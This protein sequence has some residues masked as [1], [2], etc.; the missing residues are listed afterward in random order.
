MKAGIRFP[1]C[2]GVLLA[3]GGRS[4]CDLFVDCISRNSVAI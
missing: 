3:T 1:T 4:V 2:V